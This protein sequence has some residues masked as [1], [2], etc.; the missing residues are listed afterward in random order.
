M[1]GDLGRILGRMTQSIPGLLASIVDEELAAA[2]ARIAARIAS[3]FG[4]Q[5][6]SA[7]PLRSPPQAPPLPPGRVPEVGK[8]HRSGPE[9]LAAF[10]GSI[11]KLFPGKGAE[12]SVSDVMARLQVTNRHQVTRAMR[13]LVA[14]KKLRLEG[15][16]GGAHYVRR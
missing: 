3:L 13:A 6:A 14:Q 4:V 11:L 7:H 12:L 16:K 2:R 10:Q 5:G 15:E 9:E 8:R 1:R